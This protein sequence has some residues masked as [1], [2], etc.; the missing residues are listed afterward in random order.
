[1][2][3]A[4]GCWVVGLLF[5][6]ESLL[7][8]EGFRRGSVKTRCAVLFF[9]KGFLR[10]GGRFLRVKF[11]AWKVFWQDVFFQYDVFSQNALQGLVFFL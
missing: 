1:M 5:F 4:F 3:K 10:G 9:G 2:E 7:L 8:W 11:H 6:L